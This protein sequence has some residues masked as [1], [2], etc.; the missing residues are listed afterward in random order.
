[1][2][3]TGA[4][5][6]AQRADDVL[7][8]QR[9]ARKGGSQAVLGRLAERSR[10]D[11]LLVGP[12]GVVLSSGRPPRHAVGE[13]VWRAIRCGVGELARRRARSMAIDVPGHTVFLYPLDA[14]GDPVAPVLAAV[15]PRPD[16]GGAA[17]L[18]A[19]AA[20][21]LGLCWR[22]EHTEG[23]RSRLEAAE[24]RTRE[25]VLHLLMNGHVVAARQV[26]GALGP[27]L[28][29]TVRVCV[30][31]G[32]PAARGEIAAHL[33]GS[34]PEA[35]IVPCPVYEAHLIVLA[36]AADGT[37]AAGG[38][39]QEHLPDCL[40]TAPG[41][42]WAGVSDAVPL[43]D[44]VTG[45]AQAF[46]A[47]AAARHRA[48]R[49]ASFTSSPDLP[50]LIGPAATAWAERFL[51]PLREHGARRPQ[52]PGSAELLAT[53]ASWLHFSSRATEHLKIH[54]NTLAARLKHIARCLDTDLDRL[55]DQSA[56]A[57]ALRVLTTAHPAGTAP[58]PAPRGEAA[59]H[60]LDDLLAHP[61]VTRWARV[62]L[63]PLAAGDPSGEL[64]RTLETWLDHDARV[65]AAA[66]ALSLSVTAVRKRL[67]RAEAV[68]QRSLLRPPTA[69]HDLW[70]ARRALVLAAPTEP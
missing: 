51:A 44:T 15:A 26:A 14:Q 45:Y 10:A 29:D 27:R 20:S 64:V 11:V 16:T 6:P 70:L 17:P 5:G 50:L 21:I 32:P 60:R 58:G 57:L 42:C 68:L 13:A 41:P 65:D 7:A 59:V 39:P 48:D 52:D 34:A 43:A 62:Q 1:M 37:P 12:S 30:V 2:N 22:A 55:A 46:H 19:D 31:E 4:G 18:L 23:L 36:P 49:R 33:R 54:R 56:L 69:R 35:W 61:A 25:V 28:P 66:A 47:L 40:R 3:I 63:R 38:Q 9:A 24:N 67:V 53:A 8:L